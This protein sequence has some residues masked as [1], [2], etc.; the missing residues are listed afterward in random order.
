MRIKICGITQPEQGQAIAALGI[1]TLGFI[2]VERSPRFIAPPHLKDLLATL[3]RDLHKIG[4]FVNATLAEIQEIVTLTDLTGVQLHGDESPSFCQVL[5]QEMPGVEL[6]KALRLKT[7]ESLKVV[8]DYTPFV[9]AILLDAY[10][11]QQYGGTGQVL[12]WADLADFAPPVPWFLAG[13]LTPGNIGEALKQV[14]PSGIDLSSGVERSP[15]DKDLQKVAQLLQ[16][17][18]NL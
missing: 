16:V 4:V 17:M 5:G 18:K 15:G 2:C 14:Q 12:N 1:T 6:W 8:Q 13:G 9:D 10:H 7:S 11:P 3:P